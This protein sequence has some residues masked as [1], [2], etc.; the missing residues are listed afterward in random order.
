MIDLEFLRHF[1]VVFGLGMVRLVAASS[2][3]PFLG[4]QV[5]PGQARNSILFSWGIILYPMIAPTMDGQV[6]SVTNLLAIVAKEVVLGVLIGF[7]ASKMFWIAMSVGFFIDNQR[8]SSMASVFDPMSGEQ[9][10][11]VGQF[12]QQAITVLFF[13][14]GGFLVFLGGVFESYRVWPIASFYPTLTPAFPDL[15]L[16]VT[17]DFMRSV[18]VLAAPII[19]TLFVA[20]FGLGLA[21]RFAPQLNVFVLAMPVKSILAIFVMVLY[22]PFL[23]RHF[24]DTYVGVD[25]LIRFFQNAVP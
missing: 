15:I 16:G 12:F 19:I 17:D 21:N 23:M 10:S 14:T 24:E 1:L 25:V 6:G 4:N 3:A 5:I 13:S 9:T 20:E 8:G 22:I 2:V 18:V 11:P 7:F